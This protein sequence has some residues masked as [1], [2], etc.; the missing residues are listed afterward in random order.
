MKKVVSLLLAS[1]LVVG[2][3]T[4]SFAAPKAAGYAAGVTGIEYTGIELHAGDAINFEIPALVDGSSP[5]VPIAQATAKEV[6]NA[7]V[8]V[9]SSLK[10]GSKFIDEFKIDDAVPTGSVAGT[11]KKACI[12]FSIVDPFV[13]TGDVEFN[14]FFYLNFDGKRNNDVEFHADGE[15]KINAIDVGSDDDYVDLSKGWVADVGSYVKDIEVDLG[16]EVYLHTKLFNG[17]KYF[18]VANNDVA[19]EDDTMMSKYPSIE[20]VINL[21]TIGLNAAGNIVELRDYGTGYV[22]DK[23]MKY[24]GRANER[25][26]YATKYYVSSTEIASA[27]DA[28]EGEDGE[29]PEDG[30]EGEA[31]TNVND[32]PGTGR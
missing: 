14:Y 29:A 11:P 25:L 2:M 24:L 18:G 15:I 13:S 8:T 9:R 7:K 3:S 31:P 10:S 30:G 20:N 28:E 27:D 12:V 1:A 17:K 22:Y 6:K 32:N 4:V 19:E 16:A 21:T 23:D 5:A 26:P